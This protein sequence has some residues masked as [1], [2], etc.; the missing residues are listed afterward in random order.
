MSVTFVLVCVTVGVGTYL[1]RYL[2]THFGGRGRSNGALAGPLGKFLS[3]VGLGAVAALLAAALA[4]YVAPFAREVAAGGIGREEVRSAGAALLGM[5][6]TVVV[7]RWR[8]GVASATL[9]GA[10]A[11]GL[12]W[13]L[14]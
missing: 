1:F 13:W 10:A 6:V 2:P 5:V 3:S 7:F 14:L 12:A 9:A 8:G 4:P 11:Y